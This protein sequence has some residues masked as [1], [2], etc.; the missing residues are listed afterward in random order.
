M[1]IIVKKTFVNKVPIEGIIFLGIITMFAL[2]GL[3]T[4]KV[5]N[6]AA[7][8]VKYNSAVII[9]TEE[10]KPEMVMAPGFHSDIANMRTNFKELHEA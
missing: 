8:Q 10:K 5:K 2:L 1:D 7:S 6:D 9:E 4:S 3:S